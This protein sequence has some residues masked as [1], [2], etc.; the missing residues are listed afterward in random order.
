M[1]S[2]IFGLLLIPNPFVL[3]LV[4][5]FLFIEHVKLFLDALLFILKE[6]LLELINLSLFILVNVVEFTFLKVKFT[7]FIYD[8]KATT[9]LL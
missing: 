4:C 3:N 6:L 1:D 5:D 7:I 9:L 8:W 2:T